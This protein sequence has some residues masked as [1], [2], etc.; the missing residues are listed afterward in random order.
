ME[1][2]STNINKLPVTVFLFCREQN[3]P[4]GGFKIQLIKK[5]PPYKLQAYHV[6]LKRVPPCLPAVLQ[7]RGY[8]LKLK[9]EEDVQDYTA[10][11]HSQDRVIQSTLNV[12]FLGRWPDA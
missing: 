5:R 9:Q 3:K 2:V 6:E 1:S 4:I 8:G 12:Y 11:V 10:M 7:L